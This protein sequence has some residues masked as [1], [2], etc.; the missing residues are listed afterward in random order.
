MG[1]RNYIDNTK[2]KHFVLVHGFGHGAW[3]W[4]KLL[5]LLKMNGHDASAV[6]LAG[7]GIHPTQIHEI[8]SISEYVQPLMDLLAALPS[9]QEVILVGHS[10]GGIPLSL[11]MESFPEKVSLAVFVSAYMP[12]CT[13]PPG[14]LIQEV[15]ST[16]NKLGTWNIGSNLLS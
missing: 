14:T 10:F 6:D 3:C 7:C 9:D 8:S 2:K 4:Y 5:P 12:N 13:D 16:L 11:A 15:V 1:H